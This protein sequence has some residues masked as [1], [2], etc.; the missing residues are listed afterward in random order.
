M[1]LSFEYPNGNNPIR[2]GFAVQSFEHFDNSLFI[3]PPPGTVFHVPIAGSSKYEIVHVP[4]VE[5]DGNCAPPCFTVGDVV[6]EPVFFPDEM[7]SLC[8]H[9]GKPSF[10]HPF[11]QNDS[12]PVNNSD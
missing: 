9:V 12:N 6:V 11:F 1:F 3:T 5:F 10:D 7:I 8:R 2:F 4:Y